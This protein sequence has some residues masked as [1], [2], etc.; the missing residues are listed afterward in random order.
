MRQVCSRQHDNS[1][2]KKKMISTEETPNGVYFECGKPAIGQET[3][4]VS[5]ADSMLP[6][7]DK[8]DTG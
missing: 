8:Q 3:A 2:T 7:V 1:I 5:A 6:E 4:L